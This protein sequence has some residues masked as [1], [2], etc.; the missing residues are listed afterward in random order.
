MSWL[1]VDDGFADHPKLGKLTD[2]E[3]RVWM[4][5]L[6]YCAKYRDPTVDESTANTIKG[7]DSRKIAKY[8]TVGLLDRAGDQR[9]VHDWILY[10]DATVEE[11]VGFYL[12]RAPEATANDVVRAV[13]GKR[14]LVLAEVKRL[15]EGGSQNGSRKGQEVVP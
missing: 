5:I 1:R 10:S 8:E 13:A 6:C 14:E 2:P 3:F 9:V 4:R 7:L 15:R 11:K 12:T